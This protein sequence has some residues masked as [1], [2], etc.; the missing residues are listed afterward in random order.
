LTPRDLLEVFKRLQI[1]ISEIELERFVRFLEK[2]GRGRI[3][4]SQFLNV[5]RK[6]ANK[7]YNPFKTV[8]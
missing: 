2:N 3:D 8:L 1:E 4:Y 7:N 5:M 6:K